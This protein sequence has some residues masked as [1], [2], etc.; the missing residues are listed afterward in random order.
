MQ[1]Y[2]LICILSLEQDLKHTEAYEYL[3]RLIS[4]AMLLDGEL[5][6]FHESKQMKP[7]NFCNLYPVEMDR[8]YRK[9]RLY[10][11]N[12]RSFNPELIIKLKYLMI[13]AH[14]DKILMNEIKQRHYKVIS[15]ITTLTPACATV[16]ER[17]WVKEDGLPILMSRIVSN[18]ARKCKMVFGEFEEREEEFFE[19]IEVIS[20]Q[21]TKI[22][23]K[24]GSF[25]GYKLKLLIKPDELS[26][27]LAFTIM[28]CG[29]L[30][31]NTIGLGFCRAR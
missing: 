16:G 17:S 6:E 28:G 27:K 29:I 5:K 26:Q 12:I 1:F 13:K 22:P 11:F 15:E 3:S 18:T 2:E 21:G 31:K 10:R 19:C 25:L 24:Q 9:G 8:V 7:L 30:E 23:Y 14:K 4:G 20:N